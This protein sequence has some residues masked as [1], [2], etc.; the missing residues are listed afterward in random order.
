LRPVDSHQ[1]RHPVF[2]VPRTPRERITIDLRGLA[3]ALKAHAK[4][5]HLTVSD[6]ARLAVATALE[7]SPL[8]P[9]VGP[10]GEPD[11]AA[12]QSIKL[13]VRLRRGVAARLA[14][15]ARACGLSHGT[16]LT[17]LIDGTPAPPLAVV[18]ALNAST[19]QLAVVSAD[20]NEVIRLFREQPMPSEEELDQLTQRI[21]EGVR[22]HLDL[23]SRVVADLRPART[24]PTRR[25]PRVAS[26]RAGQ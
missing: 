15:R 12:D 6:A 23:A 25:P 2:V 7:M 5:R 4:A 19:D 9:A 20:L 21:V 10:S 22:R 13:T 3:T 17:T 14:A 11:A 1:S 24:Y 16:Y 26:Q 8:D 18:A